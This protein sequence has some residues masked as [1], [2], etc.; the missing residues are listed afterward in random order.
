M[1]KVVECKIYLSK[2]ECKMLI[3]FINQEIQ[4]IQITLKLLSEN[5]YKFKNY[6]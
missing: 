4:R 6:N 1:Y 5:I 2:E 3:P